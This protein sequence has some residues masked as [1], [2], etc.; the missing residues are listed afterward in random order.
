MVEGFHTVDIP[1]PEKRE[2]PVSDEMAGGLPQV[3][4]S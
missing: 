3:G 4:E 2:L 1:Q